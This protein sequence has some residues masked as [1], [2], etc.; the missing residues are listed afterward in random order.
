MELISLIG[1]N[2]KDPI[3]ID[4]LEL[5]E[6]PVI[7]DLDRF[8]ENQPDKYWAQFKSEGLEFRFGADQCLDTIFVYIQPK[9]D[10]TAYSCDSVDFRKFVDRDEAHTFT[11]TNGLAYREGIYAPDGINWFRVEYPAYFIHYQFGTDGLNLV[12]IMSRRI[13]PNS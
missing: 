2:L 4:L 11:T 3:M 12:T 7:Y 9:G 6:V 13:A 5:H 8:F 1:I 10:I